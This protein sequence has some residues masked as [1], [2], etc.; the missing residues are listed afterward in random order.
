MLPDKC[1]LG[2]SEQPNGHIADAHVLRSTNT[3]EGI[4]LMAYFKVVSLQSLNEKEEIHENPLS[5]Q[6]T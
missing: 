4:K 2:I 1:H 6:P 3:E 5:G